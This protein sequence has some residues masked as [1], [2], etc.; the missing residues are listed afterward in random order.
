MAMRKL[1]DDDAASA[2]KTV[3]HDRDGT[4]FDWIF[5]AMANYRLNRISEAQKWLQEVT[6]QFDRIEND[7]IYDDPNWQW[8]WDAVLQLRILYNEAKNLIGTGQ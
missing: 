1:T 8:D 2:S 5:L 6:D 3:D 4:A 7:P